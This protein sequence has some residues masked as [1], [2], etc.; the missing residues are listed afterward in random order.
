V[1]EHA[2]L[3]RAM[4]AGSGVALLDTA[5]EI[6]HTHHERYDGGGYPDGLKGEEIPLGARIIL[7]A[8]AL[9]SM[10]TS[11][12]YRGARPAEEAVAELRSGAGTQFCPRC[13]AA[14]ERALAVTPAALHDERMLVA[15]TA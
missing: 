1:Q 4:L 9:D 15:T 14:L 5:A 13:V 11:H 7:V 8:D 2:D 6:A 3:G 10:L 12:V